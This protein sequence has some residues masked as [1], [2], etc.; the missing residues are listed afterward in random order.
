MAGFLTNFGTAVGGFNQGYQ[1]QQQDEMRRQLQAL[2][3]AEAQRKAQMERQQLQ[4]QAMAFGSLIGGDAGGVGGLS[5]LGGPPQQ[6]QMPPE[7][8]SAP[9]RFGGMSVPSG[10]TGGNW[11]TR[12]NN[13]AGMRKPGVYAGPNAGGFQ[14]FATPEEGLSKI[15]WQLDRYADGKTTGEPLTTL[16]QIVSTWAP[17]ATPQNPREN[18]TPLL[19]QRASQ[20]TGFAPDQPLNV[21]DPAVKA[22]LIEA[23][24]RGEQGGKLP[25]D[26]ALIAKVAGGV[27]AQ[28]DQRPRTEVPKVQQVQQTAQQT[29][30]TIDPF[31][32]GRM[33]LQALARQV[34]KTNP[35]ADPAVKM[36]AVQ[37]LYK[38]LA[39]EQREYWQLLMQNHR[40]TVQFE[41]QQ[42]REQYQDD[43]QQRLFQQQSD[44]ED[45]REKARGDLAGPKGYTLMQPPG[46][47]P[48]MWVKPGQPSIPVDAPGGSTKLGT[49]NQGPADPKQVEYVAKGIAGYNMS[50]L[51]G[52]ALR[53]P[54]GKDVM[55]KVFEINPEYDQTKYT[56][57]QRG[58]TAFTS[59]KQGDAIRSFSVSID[60]LQTMQEVADALASGDTQT[61]NRLQNTIEK[62]LGYSGPVDF[63]FVSS[64]V[65]AEVSKAI[66][67]GVGA[68]KDR[69]ELRTSFDAVNSPEQL[70]G[71]IRRAKQLMAGQLGGYRRQAGTAGFSQQDFEEALSPAAKRELESLGAGAPAGGGY[72]VGQVIEKGGKKYRVTG[73]DPNDPDVEEV[74]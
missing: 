9:G 47:G 69:E 62:Q 19:L 34:D 37:E 56:A 8:Q 27:G 58:A 30:Q 36:M 38:L 60:H 11:E 71:I 18:N 16:R 13:F 52:Y 33:S 41:M 12:N 49:A 21:K 44:L 24:I 57:K 50:P 51:S 70:A 43:R 10:G 35:S 42:R 40:E 4:S 48:A 54:F 1:Q 28:G 66:I 26:Q 45:R 20:V 25:V 65:G 2:A 68:L 31:V 17:P 22:K 67:G 73:G 32:Q 5:A 63:N 14:S 74:R 61:I 6:P 23:M 46:G 7:G 3:M 39:P 59:G 55:A 64:I 72:S 15:S 53:S 29:A